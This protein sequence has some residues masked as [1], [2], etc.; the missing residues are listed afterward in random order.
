M[1]ERIQIKHDLEENWQK[2][3]NFI[4]LA[5]ELIIYDGI[6]EDGQY[7]KMPQFK[8]GDGKTCINNLPF[9]QFVSEEKKNY[10][11]DSTLIING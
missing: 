11:Q 8:L 2:A 10:A 5:G 1:R 6:I 4:P 7:I 9:M 3:V